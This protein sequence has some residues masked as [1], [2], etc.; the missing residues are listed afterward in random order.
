VDEGIFETL[1]DA[2][3]VV[4]DGAIDA[5]NQAA[6]ALFGPD[7][8]GRALDEVLAEGERRR[9]ELLV[10]QRAR[11]WPIPASCRLKFVR[12]AER[13]EIT[14]DVRFAER[15]GALILSARDVTDV[16]RAEHLMGKLAEI[17]TRGGA[18]LGTDHLFDET[19]PVFLALGWIVAFTEVLEGKRS[20]TR[21]VIAAP[22]DPVGAYGK[23]II[24][25]ELPFEK[26]PV[27]AEVV[28]TGRP[29]FLDNL[30]TLQQG[31][32]RAATALGESM[33]RAQVIRSAWCPIITNGK[34]SHLLAVTGRDLTDHDFVAVQLFAAQIGAAI[35]M[36]ALRHALVHQ[37]RLAAVGQMAAVMAHEVRNPLGT[38]FNAVAS[39]RRGSGS[40]NLPGLLDILQ[41]EADRLQRLVADLLDFSRPS[42]V[43]VAPVDLRP[44]LEHAIE[45]ARLDPALGGKAKEVELDIAPKLSSIDTDARLLHR[46]LVN[47]LVNALQNVDADGKVSLRA[48]VE[49]DLL[50]ITVH[51]DG[52]PIARELAERLFEPFFTTRATG[53]GLGL[54]VVRR[55]AEDLGGSVKLEPTSEGTRFLLALPISPSSVPRERPA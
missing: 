51:N 47:L 16:T 24:G 6:E 25:V 15:A 29:A 37:E 43:E 48:A 53:T 19:T 17:F 13:G 21:R 52:A 42:V 46:A 44:I 12:G 34:L 20:I 30:P 8:V 5:A 22:G 27:L 4:R 3:V 31:P 54:A 39:L 11:G 26:T 1:P 9:L 50:C 55:I 33:E 28:R 40:T 18:L 7:L 35:H 14:A 49:R 23:T 36:R 38:I 41:E 2:V 45:A 32:E 10:A